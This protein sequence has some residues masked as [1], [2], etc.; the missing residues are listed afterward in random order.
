MLENRF[1]E[2]V[3][4]FQQS[5]RV[6]RDRTGG[7]GTSGS[8]QTQA[9]ADNHRAARLKRV[10]SDRASELLAM[11]D[12]EAQ[13][14]GVVD[15]PASNAPQHS[16]RRKHEA[17][18]AGSVDPLGAHPES[19]SSA[20]GAVGAIMGLAG[21]VDADRASQRGHAR[22]KS[23]RKAVHST[24]TSYVPT[25]PA[26]PKTA[27]GRAPIESGPRAVSRPRGKPQAQPQT[28]H[29]PEAKHMPHGS[30]WGAGRLGL[31]PDAFAASL[32]LAARAG[33]KTSKHKQHR[34][35]SGSRSGSKAGSSSSSGK[36]RRSTG[37]A[38]QG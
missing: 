15:G 11:V 32:A 36:K 34:T 31:S 19:H 18:S 21:E 33:A 20:K 9:R 16:R 12:D 7:F 10:D 14:G 23:R 28:K 25:S 3:L 13:R 8:A 35:G 6:D 38:A 5:V 30:G 29:L 27:Q 22:S 4:H 37:K 24:S 2:A 1:D 26:A 17:N